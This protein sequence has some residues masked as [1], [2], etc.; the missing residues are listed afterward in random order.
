LALGAKV[1][2]VGDGVLQQANF[3]EQEKVASHPKVIALALMGRTINNFAAMR[4]LIEQGFIVE[5]RTLVRCCWENLFWIG[6]L[7]AEGH[8]F[9]DKVVGS[10]VMNRRKRGR[11]LLDWAKKQ[12]QTSDFESQLEQYLG[13]LD[14]AHPTPSQTDFKA[15]AE[16]GKI[17]DGYIIYRVLSADAA[18]P[19]VT[20]LDR[21]LHPKSDN[22]LD[23][24]GMPLLEEY[25]V[26]ETL[27]FGCN[28]LLACVIGTNK[29][30][31][32]TPAGKCLGA[33]VED[34]RSLSDRNAKARR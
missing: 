29:F 3:A 1:L 7:T 28:A 24:T 25:E 12:K 30:M 23:L 13:R 10:E 18:H 33:L 17:G 31:G 16:A 21:H 22:V 5:A 20:S 26:E 19:S 14:A 27:E 6:G 32:G 8:Q 2:D 34:F 11:E 9:V 15:A 4:V